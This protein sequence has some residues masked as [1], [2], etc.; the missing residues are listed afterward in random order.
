MPG[1]GAYVPEQEYQSHIA[2]HVEEVEVHVCDIMRSSPKCRLNE[3]LNRLM[4]VNRSMML[5][6]TRVPVHPLVMPFRVPLW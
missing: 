2:D 4:H 5:L 1:W 3:R 6:S